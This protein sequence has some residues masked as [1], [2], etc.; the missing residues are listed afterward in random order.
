[1]NAFPYEVTM[2]RNFAIGSH[3]HTWLLTEV[4]PRETDWIY[5]KKQISENDKTRFVTVFRFKDEHKAFLF[6]VAHC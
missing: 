3:A 1:M 5:A 2:E 4:G 6:K